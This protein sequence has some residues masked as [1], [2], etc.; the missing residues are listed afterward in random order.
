MVLEFFFFA[1]SVVVCIEVFGVDEMVS[2]ENDDF[3]A[4]L[5]IAFAGDVVMHG[6]HDG[7]EGIT[8][9]IAAF[10]AGVV[11]DKFLGNVVISDDDED[12]VVEL[13]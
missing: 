10:G 6:V 12:M 13:F 3:L 9:I 1:K 7:V 11:S 5:G 2:G 4:L 8:E